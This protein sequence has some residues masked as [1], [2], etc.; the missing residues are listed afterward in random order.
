MAV[1]HF[2][3]VWTDVLQELLFSQKG[4]LE[5]VFDRSSEAMNYGAIDIPSYKTTLA[6]KAVDY[7]A[8]V[9]HTEMTSS[10][11]TLSLNKD[12]YDSVKIKRADL[13]K[14]KSGLSRQATIQL[15]Q[16]MRKKLNDDLR[17]E[18]SGSVPAGNKTDV[19]LK[20]S[21]V[22]ETSNNKVFGSK[23]GRKELMEAIAGRAD[24][25]DAKFW[26]EGNRAAM[27][28]PYIKRQIARYFT[29]DNPN[30]A[31]APIYES[32]I[33]DGEP[34]MRVFGFEIM[35]DQDESIAA[36]AHASAGMDKYPIF[37]GLKGDSLHFARTL[38]EMRIKT[39]KDDFWEYLQPHA[40][41]GAE[42]PDDNRTA[43]IQFDLTA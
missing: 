12:I 23:S 17:T 9:T 1:T 10:K 5:M 22:A 3:T 25:A 2:G 40:L 11:A 35:T 32:T 36:D 27:C 13:M 19:A 31:S 41:Y 18:F 43:L 6:A 29:F 4:W 28:T 38:F 37:F 33:R 34:I 16:S 7:G 15:A 26:P 24:L 42:V 8:V 30:L 39:D 20:H 21:G 14:S